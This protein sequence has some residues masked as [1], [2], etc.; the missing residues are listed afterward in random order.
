MLGNTLSANRDIGNQQRMAISAGLFQKPYMPQTY[1]RIDKPHSLYA[2]AQAG[3]M[4]SSAGRIAAGIGDIDKANAVKLQGES[5]AE[6]LE[7]QGQQADLSRM[8]QLRGQQL[9]TRASIDQY[10]TGVLGE[11]RARSADAFSKVH[12]VNAN[13]INAQNT[14]ANNYITAADRDFKVGQYRADMNK[15]WNMMNDPALKSMSKEYTNLVGQEE[16]DKRKAAFEALKKANPSAVGVSTFEESAGY[17]TYQDEIKRKQ[18]ELE[19]LMEPVRMRQQ[20]MQYFAPLQFAKKGG[21]VDLT[22]QDRMEIDNNKFENL[23]RL[24][25]TELTYKAIMHNNEILQKSLIKVFK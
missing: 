13:Q 25:S 11:N 6:A 21:K 7:I 2:D 19:Q 18:A 22:K 9:Q 3:K 23:K 16:Y 14:A 8:D 24:R 1:L 10:N 20:Q 5:Q 15:T 12:L 17:K 4:R